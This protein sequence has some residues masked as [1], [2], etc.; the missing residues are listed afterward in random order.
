VRVSDLAEALALRPTGDGHWLAFADPRYQSTNE[1][2]GGWT[3]AVTLRGAM[4]SSD[5]A[6]TPS[7]ITINFVRLVE[8]G[9]ECSFVCTWSAEDDRYNTGGPR[10]SPRKTRVYWPTQ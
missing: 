1:M 5:E 3:A 8:S 4:Q 2:F 7:A 6:A 10:S 9:T